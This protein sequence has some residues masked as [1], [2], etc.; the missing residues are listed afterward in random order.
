MTATMTEPRPRRACRPQGPPAGHPESRPVTR[1]AHPPALLA[2]TAPTPVAPEL[3][4]LRSWDEVLGTD[5]LGTDVPAALPVPWD[6]T[7]TAGRDDPEPSPRRERPEGGRPQRSRRPVRAGLRLPPGYQPALDGLRAVAILAVLVDHSGVAGHRPFFGVDTFF[8][9]TGF[10]LTASALREWH[11]T[12]GID[13]VSYYR[14]RFKRLIP[15][16]VLMLGLIAWALLE[17]GS[18]AEIDRFRVQA[19][20]SLAFATNWEQINAGESYWDGFGTLNP[21]GHMWSLAV[22][23]QLSMVWPLLL[24]LGLTLVLRRRRRHRDHVS[25]WRL[26]LLAALTLAGLATSTL[27]QLLS[28]DGSNADRLYLGTDAHAQ[29]FFAGACVGILLHLWTL[30]RA[31]RTAAGVAPRL[32]LWR[33]LL[34]TVTSVGLLTSLV[35]IVLGTHQ[36]TDAW[37]YEKGGFALVAVVAASLSASLTWRGNLLGKVLAWTP[38]VEIGKVSYSLYLV[39]QPLFW[40]I[41]TLEPHY[42][43]RDV[44]IVGLPGSLLIAGALHHLIAEPLRLRRWRPRVMVGFVTVV[45]TVTA[46]VWFTPVAWDALHTGRGDVQVLTLGD[47]VANDFASALGTYSA[48]EVSVTDGGLPG[49]GIIGAVRMRT[50]VGITQGA[51]QGCNPWRDRYERAIADADPDVIVLDLAW[52]SV[53][54]DLGDGTWTDLTDPVTADGYREQLDELAEVTDA[55]GV[56]VLIA[57]TRPFNAVNTPEQAAAFNQVLAEAMVKHPAWRQLDLAGQMCTA[58]ECPTL[59]ADGAERYVDDRVHFSREGKQ[60]LAPWLVAQIEAALRPTGKA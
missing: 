40:L 14:R 36:Y 60:E 56:P 53:L 35:M 49:C 18:R 51:P 48:S 16:T 4:P 9:L 1:P 38:L 31:R 27:I 8:T 23:E 32:S 55:A 37:L 17:L 42:A 28:F 20:A 30:R 13:L 5:P 41:L 7:D 24:V 15:A 12:G 47:S 43:P 22:T 25:V 46:G 34:V 39:H 33:S 2:G 6:R 59:T 26:W 29:G 10:L 19:L 58:D 54:S 3:P 52:D 44:L 11:R 45:A 57:T 21:L 50:D